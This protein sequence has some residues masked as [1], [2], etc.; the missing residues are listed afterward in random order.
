M[1]GPDGRDYK[2][3]VRYVEV[4]RPSLLVY[5]HGGEEEMQDVRFRMKISL[6][7]LGGRTELAMRHLFPTAEERDRVVREFGAVEGARNT[8]D[9]LAA[10]LAVGSK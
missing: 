3:I 7:D 10:F 4:E 6:V 1:H 8:L 9:R 2:N 5:D